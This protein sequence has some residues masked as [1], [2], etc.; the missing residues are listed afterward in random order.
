M[1]LENKINASIVGNMKRKKPSIPNIFDFCKLADALNLSL[2]YILYGDSSKVKMETKTPIPTESATF[3]N[4]FNNQIS[5]DE[6]ILL[7]T[8]REVNSI[9]KNQ[10][11]NH[12]RNIWLECKDEKRG[13]LLD[14]T[15][16][17]K[18]G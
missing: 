4:N 10:I 16:E 7:Q 9:G 6:H 8:Y 1:L 12:L 11:Q 3:E 5:V 13:E 17:N 2:D 15:L 14:S 18:I